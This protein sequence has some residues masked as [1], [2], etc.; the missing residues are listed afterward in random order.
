VVRLMQYGCFLLVGSH[1]VIPA[2]LRSACLPTISPAT[3]RARS[4]FYTTFGAFG[5]AAQCHLPLLSTF[6][7]A[8]LPSFR[9]LVWILRV[10]ATLPSTSSGC[11]LPPRCAFA[12]AL[13]LRFYHTGLPATTHGSRF[14]LSH[15]TAPYGFITHGSGQLRC[16][17][18]RYSRLHWLRWF[19]VTYLG[20]AYLQFY[21]RFV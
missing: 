1:R 10:F 14:I 7:F 12:A 16:F 2:Y 6:G 3:C 20:S 18:C 19:A 4:A 8:A 5:H 15:H 11:V 21:L 13:R 17:S 9:L